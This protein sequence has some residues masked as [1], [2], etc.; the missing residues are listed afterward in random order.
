MHHLSQFD[1]PSPGEWRAR[2]YDEPA[3]IVREL[4]EDATELVLIDMRW[5][6]LAKIALEIMV[7]RRMISL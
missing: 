4:Y 7:E 1:V 6:Q 3:E 2:L 5:Y